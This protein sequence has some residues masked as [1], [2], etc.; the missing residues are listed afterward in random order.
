MEEPR[1]PS[2]RKDRFATAR[3]L[4]ENDSYFDAFTDHYI[5]DAIIVV[6]EH[7]DWAENPSNAAPLAIHSLFRLVDERDPLSTEKSVSIRK[8]VVESTLDEVKLVLD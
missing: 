3:D 2:L 1:D 4:I 5:N 6:V 8:L 7:E